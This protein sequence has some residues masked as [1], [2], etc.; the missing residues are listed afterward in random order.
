LPN[1]LK[2][3]TVRPSTVEM[4]GIAVRRRKGLAMR[5]AVEAVEVRG[6]IGQLG[7]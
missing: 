3:V 6:E 2:P 7:H 1:L 4:G 5:R